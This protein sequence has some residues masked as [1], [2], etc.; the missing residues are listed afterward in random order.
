MSF[1]VVY[2]S[3]AM[4]KLI[5]NDISKHCQQGNKRHDALVVTYPASCSSNPCAETFSG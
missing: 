2:L 1:L 3:P 4:G 5:G